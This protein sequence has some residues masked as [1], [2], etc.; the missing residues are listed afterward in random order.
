MNFIEPGL[1]LK[2]EDFNE[3]IKE[4]L[5]T[6][7]H[8]TNFFSSLL[9]DCLVFSFHRSFMLEAQATYQLFNMI[10][11]FGHKGAKAPTR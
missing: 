10:I 1:T 11:G 2:M 9:I 4:R 7:Y 8:Q 3:R 6:T 5:L